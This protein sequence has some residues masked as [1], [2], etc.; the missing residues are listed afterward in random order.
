MNLEDRVSKV[1]MYIEKCFEITNERTMPLGLL[2][3]PRD[4]IIY[5]TLKIHLSRTFKQY[6][7]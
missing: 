3:K 7:I 6:T 2:N 5:C 4:T 1:I